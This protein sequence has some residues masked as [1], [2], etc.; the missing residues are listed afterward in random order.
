[1]TNLGNTCYMNSVL[2]ALYCTDMFRK[3]V[4]RNS[5]SPLLNALSKVFEEMSD[6][7]SS[8]YPSS[9]RNQLIKL[10]PKFRGYDQQD[11]QEFLRYLINGIH[12]E[13]NQA[14]RYHQKDARRNLK[15][16]TCQDELFLSFSLET[17]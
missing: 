4:L 9:F 15:P 12:D 11:A 6:D 13:I 8:V 7:K 17:F 3:F 14:N 5:K 10:Y 16:R 2:Q 1:M